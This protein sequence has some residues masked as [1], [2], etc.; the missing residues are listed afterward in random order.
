MIVDVQSV[1]NRGTAVLKNHGAG[2]KVSGAKPHIGVGTQGLP[3]ANAVISAEVS[4]RTG[5]A[6]GIAALLT[7]PGQV[8]AAAV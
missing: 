1:K 7:C 3:S 8:T 4:D 2:S 5:G 6:Q